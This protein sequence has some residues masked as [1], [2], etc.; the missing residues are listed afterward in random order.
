MDQAGKGSALE[1]TDTS[2]SL[3][4]NS[5]SLFID[6]TNGSVNASL[7]N[8]TFYR[9]EGGSGQDRGSVSN[10]D[11]RGVLRASVM[12]CVFRG[13][14]TGDA[15]AGLSLMA[16]TQTPDQ[17]T[18]ASIVDTSF[19]SQRSS[20]G[21]DPLTCTARPLPPSCWS[22]PWASS[23][24]LTGFSQL[25]IDSSRFQNNS[26]ISN[27]KITECVK[28]SISRSIMVGNSVSGQGGAVFIANT[29]RARIGPAC[30]FDLNRANSSFGFGGAIH[31]I[32][33]SMDVFD[34]SFEGNVA[35]AS[36]GALALSASGLERSSLYFSATNV[37][38]KNNS[39][40]IQLSNPN[41]PNGYGGGGFYLFLESPLNV[42]QL[43]ASNIK[44]RPYWQNDRVQISN[45]TFIDNSA[46]LIGG[47]LVVYV[48]GFTLRDCYFINNTGSL[49]GAVAG[50]TNTSLV[51]PIAMIFNCSF[52]Q[53]SARSYGSAL[54]FYWYSAS[55][56]LSRFTNNSGSGAITGTGAASITT[57]DS[58][59]GGNTG[60]TGA[61]L[62][63][64]PSTDP[65]MPS[66]APVFS[67]L[68]RCIFEDNAASGLGGGA[69]FVQSVQNMRISACSFNRNVAGGGS[70]GA[71][72][73]SNSPTNISN[74]NF[75]LNGANGGPG[76]GVFS[77]DSTMFVTGSTFDQNSALNQGAGICS[78]LIDPN[79]NN[80]LS[81]SGASSFTG[82]SVALAQGSGG[83]VYVSILTLAA[84][85]SSFIGN[86]ALNGPG[87]AALGTSVTVDTTS[88]SLVC[89]QSGLGANE[90][91]T[92]CNDTALFFASLP[93]PVPPSPLIELS[94]GGS[95]LGLILGLSIGLGL[96]A[97]FFALF[98]L[99]KNRQQRESTPS[100]ETEDVPSADLKLHT[101]WD[102]VKELEQLTT[103]LKIERLARATAHSPDAESGL[104][105]T[106]SDFSQSGNS[107]LPDTLEI[108]EE[109]GKGGQGNVYRGRWKGTEVA[110][111]TFVFS[112]KESSSKRSAREQASP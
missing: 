81:I 71:A 107:S 44:T 83:A 95:R 108:N 112:H 11:I 90:K 43:N 77:I 103:S 54:I 13:C 101:L 106:V 92:K 111:K 100:T 89:S 70:G 76:G 48:T 53:N 88:T 74:S 4:S 17:L 34:S 98:L 56:F 80:L 52:F 7:S 57:A 20:L 18:F 63:L 75:T 49:G 67:L 45:S 68:A 110:I 31:G 85:N 91:V 30:S 59:F 1:A 36:G 21:Q 84:S 50:G 39:C 40:L 27:V 28:V 109:I 42:A 82:N 32:D 55:I 78:I 15:V 8:C 5:S 72:Y 60:Q 51:P 29:T 22:L 9:S 87:L 19:L 47:G 35:W 25:S 96:A 2:W 58:Y 99:C 66:I 10:V 6:G 26:G 61:A 65:S 37:T 41:R 73:L 79:A 24:Y 3:N 16:L 105:P 64:I 102:P 86:S 97:V 94:S 38:V 33:V 46:L 23:A 62:A 93:N 14:S 12:G 104:V 69:I